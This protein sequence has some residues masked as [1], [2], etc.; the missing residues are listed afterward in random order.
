VQRIAVSTRGYRLQ[1]SVLD[2]QHKLPEKRVRNTSILSRQQ[3]RS[4]LVEKIIAPSK[5]PNGSANVDYV[6]KHYTSELNIEKRWKKAYLMEG[7]YI[8]RADTPS[9]SSF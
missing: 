1:L 7:T 2:T 8:G 9:K 3:D 4:K 6:T 5:S